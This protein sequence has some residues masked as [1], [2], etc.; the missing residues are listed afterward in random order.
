[1]IEQTSREVIQRRAMLRDEAKAIV[2]CESLE[3]ETTA[4]PSF[5][6]ITAEVCAIV[7]DSGVTNGQVTVYSL[8]TTAAVKIQENEPLLLRDLKRTLRQAAPSDAYYE[9]NDFGRRTVNMRP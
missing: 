6:N 1:M 4:A 5:H 2:T 9:H 3:V 8:H 7:A